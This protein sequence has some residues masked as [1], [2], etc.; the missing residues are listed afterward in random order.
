[1]CS[2]SDCKTPCWP[3]C[4]W[5]WY[6]AGVLAGMATATAAATSVLT[7]SNSNASARTPLLKLH[8]WQQRL[9]PDA[10]LSRSGDRSKLWLVSAR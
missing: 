10:P 5:G 7:G 6:L 1:M 9:R 4:W 2:Q 8:V 3:A